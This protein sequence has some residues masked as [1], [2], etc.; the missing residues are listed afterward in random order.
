[1]R[2]PDVFSRIGVGPRMSRG[3]MDTLDRLENSITRFVA[4]Y[5][6]QREQ[7]E[8]YSGE[9]LLVGVELEQ[10]RDT[11]AGLKEDLAR[12]AET[13]DRYREFDARKDELREQIRIIVEKLDRFGDQDGLGSVTNA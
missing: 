9:L 1:M 4:A 5:R 2:K 8:H 6:K 12:C 13:G 3:I 10:A 11:I 7:S